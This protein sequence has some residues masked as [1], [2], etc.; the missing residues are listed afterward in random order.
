MG[1]MGCEVRASLLNCGPGN[2]A[3]FARCFATAPMGKARDRRGESSV[4]ASILPYERPRIPRRGPERSADAQLPCS[5]T[6]SN[7]VLPRRNLAP[8][9]STSKKSFPLRN[10]MQ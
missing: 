7:V 8:A 1:A 6:S 9:I 3:R 4:I 5:R 10:S 2:V